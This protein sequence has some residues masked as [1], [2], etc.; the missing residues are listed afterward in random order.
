MESDEKRRLKSMWQYENDAFSRGF[1][2]IAG[3]DEAGRGPLAGPV[4]AA[5]AILPRGFMLENCNDSKQLSAK[6]RQ[7]LYEE[8]MGNPEIEIGIGVVPHDKIDE[9]NILRATIHAMTFAVRDLK[10]QPDFVL[11]DAL[12]IP[13]LGIENRGVIRGDSRSIT[14]AAASIVAKQTRDNLMLEYDRQ[15]P[16][17]G[18]AKH[19]GYGTKYHQEM[20]KIHGPSPIHRK[21]F[22][23]A[24]EQCEELDLWQTD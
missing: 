7:E 5:A 20:L 18:F 10:K 6:L 12:F 17:Y 24:R 16:Q 23:P 21:T 3:M 15:Y 19:K 9:I 1:S 2:V 11:I 14:I 4:V 13:D 22:L 8:I